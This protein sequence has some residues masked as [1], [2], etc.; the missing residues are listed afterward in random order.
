[1]TDESHKGGSKANQE[2]SEKKNG[3]RHSG[4]AIRSSNEFLK[5]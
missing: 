2:P 1:M 3:R 4:E 5:K